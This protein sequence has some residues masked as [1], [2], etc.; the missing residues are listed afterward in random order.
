VST[1]FE[2]FLCGRVVQAPGSSFTVAEEGGNALLA[3][4]AFLDI[5]DR[6]LGRVVRAGRAYAFS[7]SYTNGNPRS[8]G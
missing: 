6:V 4:Q 7:L 8:V 5:V 2:G 3:A 1:G